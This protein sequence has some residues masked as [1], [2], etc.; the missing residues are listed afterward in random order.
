M[1][2]W[3]CIVEDP[4]KSKSGGDNASLKTEAS[5]TTVTA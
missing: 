1:Y 3:L 2:P 4:K 5:E